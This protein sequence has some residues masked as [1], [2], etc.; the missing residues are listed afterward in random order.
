MKMDWKFLLIVSIHTIGIDPLP[1]V[2]SYDIDT[3]ELSYRGGG[4]M[5][6]DSERG[7]GIEGNDN[8][9]KLS[10]GWSGVGGW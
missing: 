4:K 8:D 6:L 2:P 10:S 1:F 9:N 5:K 3:K 7:G